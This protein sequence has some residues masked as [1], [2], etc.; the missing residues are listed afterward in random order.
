MLS[1]DLEELSDPARRWV[2]FFRTATRQDAAIAIRMGFIAAGKK[3]G[4]TR[5]IFDEIDAWSQK[6]TPPQWTGN[7]VGLF[8]EESPGEAFAEPNSMKTKME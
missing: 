4:F 2:Q 5:C 6:S 7:V 8:E 3:P 1:K